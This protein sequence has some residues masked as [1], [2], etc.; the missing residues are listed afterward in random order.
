MINRFMLYLDGQEKNRPIQA[1]T[2]AEVK[3]CQLAWSVFTVVP[4]LQ[5]LYVLFG[6]RFQITPK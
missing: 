2:L 5:K 1:N 4:L 3:E 6:V